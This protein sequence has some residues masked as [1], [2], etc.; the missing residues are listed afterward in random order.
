[1]LVH[2]KSF[3]EA[4]FLSD[5]SFPCYHGSS[6]STNILGPDVLSRVHFAI[7]DDTLPRVVGGLRSLLAILVIV[8]LCLVLTFSAVH[9]TISLSFPFAESSLGG[10]FFILFTLFFGLHFLVQSLFPLLFLLRYV[11]NQLQLFRGVVVMLKCS[12]GTKVCFLTRHLHT[13]CG[14][15]WVAGSSL[16]KSITVFGRSK[17]FK[18]VHIRNLKSI[19]NLL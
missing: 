6:H 8:L 2:S 3:L 19:A 9:F 7:V 16:G 17:S 18:L 4:T 14:S 10:Q 5:I 15:E 12:W 13:S 1:M 11:L